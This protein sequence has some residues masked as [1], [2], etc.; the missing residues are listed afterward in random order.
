MKKSLL[1]M[2]VA[3]SMT[4]AP[5]TAFAEDAE[6]ET[7]YYDETE[8][9]TEG[10]GTMVI[11]Q[12]LDDQN[13]VWTVGLDVATGEAA[14]NLLPP[15]EDGSY[16][17]ANSVTVSGPSTTTDDGLI[18]T[19]EETGTEYTFGMSSVE[20]STDQVK[21]TYEE[22]GSEVILSLV[23]TKEASDDENMVF[24]AGLDDSGN[25]WTFGFD[26]DNSEIAANV[27]TTDGQ[28]VT[29]S[30]TFV[31]DGEGTLTI[32]DEN[33]EAA[34]WTYEALDENWTAIKLTDQEGASLTL[35]LVNNDILTA[36]EAE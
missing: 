21:L 26:F 1:A 20:G 17:Q 12:G 22:T 36:A 18:I 3:L 14:V 23:D 8:A 7:E 31:D 28:E 24:Y 11:M 32:T 2:G 34:D 27:K 19:D 35:S 13:I 25:Q 5:L 9:G 10:A 6:Y 16:D 15:S 4:L 30:G 33:G 29:Q